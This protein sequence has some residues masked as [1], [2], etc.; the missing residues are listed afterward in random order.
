MGGGAQRRVVACARTPYDVVV[1]YCLEYFGFPDLDL[2]QEGWARVDGVPPEAAS[3]VSYA[4][5][6]LDRHVGVVVHISSKIYEIGL[7]L[8]EHLAG[9]LN[10]E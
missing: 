4:L 1:Q 5:V 2:G 10:A 7:C 9:R 6:D 8:L 3:I